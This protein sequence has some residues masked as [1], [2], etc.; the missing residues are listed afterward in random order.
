[1]LTKKDFFFLDQIILDTI[2]I[3]LRKQIA[4]TVFCSGI[5]VWAG[6]GFNDTTSIFMT[7]KSVNLEVISLYLAQDRPQHV[8]TFKEDNN[9]Q[10]LSKQSESI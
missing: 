3:K 9:E 7:S 5:T 2:G 10:N 4:K 1:M 6:K 8:H